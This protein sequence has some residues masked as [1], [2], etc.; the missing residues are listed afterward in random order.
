[1]AAPPSA[2][3]NS[4]RPMM[5]VIR[6]LPC[7]V[8]KEGYHATSVQSSRS[9]RAG[10]W[11]LAP[12]SGASGSEAG[13]TQNEGEE[14]ISQAS[15]HDRVHQCRARFASSRSHLRRRAS[16]GPRLSRRAVSFIGSRVAPPSDRYSYCPALIRAA[17]S[18][19]TVAV[20]PRHRLE[21]GSIQTVSRT[22]GADRVFTNN[23]EHSLDLRTSAGAPI[24]VT[25]HDN[26]NTTQR[27]RWAR[28][29][30]PPRSR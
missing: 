15:S 13:K 22:A 16:C 20:M 3:S 5:V 9:R 19:T 11:L 4:R 25:S 23:R 21:R 10:C 8:R 30:S 28:T 14:K 29:T 17:V 2:A 24:Y 12:L 1:T 6:P 7:E 18:S 27:R 26:R